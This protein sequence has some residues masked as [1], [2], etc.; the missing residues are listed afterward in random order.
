MS[1]RLL[2]SLAVK[3]MSPVLPGHNSDTPLGCTVKGKIV[4]KGTIV[5]VRIDDRKKRFTLSN[6]PGSLQMVVPRP[7]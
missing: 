2:T 3:V 7:V 1:I 4:C 5:R 6:C